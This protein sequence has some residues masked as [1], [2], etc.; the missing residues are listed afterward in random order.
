MVDNAMNRTYSVLTIKKRNNFLSLKEHEKPFF[1]PPK[2]VGL[3]QYWPVPQKINMIAGCL[4]GFYYKISF[5]K[6]QIDMKAVLIYQLIKNGLYSN[7]FY[8]EGTLLFSLLGK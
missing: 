1:N 8:L 4:K 2:Y 7:P 5:E 6:H 3:S